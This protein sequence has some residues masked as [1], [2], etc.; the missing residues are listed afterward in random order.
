MKQSL[1]QKLK[2]KL[3]SNQYK[4]SIDETKIDTSNRIYNKYAEIKSEILPKWFKSNFNREEAEDYLRDKEV[5]VFIIRESE[6][7]L[8]CYVLSVKCS[9]YIHYTGKNEISNY[10]NNCIDIYSIELKCN[11]YKQEASQ[12]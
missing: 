9:K 6:T 2:L 7:I 8:D 10:L 11:Y 4:K 12:S 1:F 3:K 5:G